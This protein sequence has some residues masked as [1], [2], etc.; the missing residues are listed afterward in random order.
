[1]E[2]SWDGVSLNLRGAEASVRQQ[3]GRV[4]LHPQC[5]RSTSP[6]ES[7]QLTPGLGADVGARLSPATRGISWLGP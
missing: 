3:S 1:M 4:A 6:D 7:G 2:T 5:N